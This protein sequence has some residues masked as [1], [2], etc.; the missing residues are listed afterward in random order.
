MLSET[1]VASQGF[2]T[3]WGHTRGCVHRQVHQQ[4]LAAIAED[5]GQG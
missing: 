3:P 4:S 1:D 5:R 2:G